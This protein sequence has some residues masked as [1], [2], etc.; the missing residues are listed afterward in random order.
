MNKRG[1]TPKK[2]AQNGSN[3]VPV[4][5]T[6]AGAIAGGVVTSSPAITAGGAVSGL[7]GYSIGLGSLVAKVGCGSAVAISSLSIIAAG[8]VIGGIIGFS[9]YKALK[10]LKKQNGVNGNQSN[11]GNSKDN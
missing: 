2:E 4:L 10:G 11:N 5:S 9:A 1:E 3:A 6:T 7:T 8:P